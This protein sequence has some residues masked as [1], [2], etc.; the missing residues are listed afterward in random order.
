VAPLLAAVLRARGPVAGN[1][2]LPAGP[3]QAFLLGWLSGALWY[4]GSCYWVAYT[5]HIYGGLDM[6]ASL[7][8]LVLFCLWLGAQTG[9]FALL[10]SL[11][12]NRAR[13]PG[14]GIRRAL[15]CAPFLWVAIELV[16]TR[17]IGF[18][19]DLLGTAQVDNVPLTRLAAVTGVYGLSFEIMVVN[20][21]FAAAFLAQRRGRRLLLAAAV[22]A[23][24]ALQLSVFVQPPPAPAGA[25][26]RL[27]QENVPIGE[28]W[29]PETYRRTL[30]ELTR[31][32]MPP[33]PFES[34]GEPNA[35]LIV[36]PESPAP[37]FDNEPMF[38]AQIS[39]L[40]SQAHAY[41]I[42]GVLGTEAAPRGSLQPEQ[43][44]NSAALITPDGRW[45]AR[46]DKV[47]LVPFGEYVPFKKLFGFAHQLTRE[48]GDFVPGGQRRV[49]DLGGYRAGTFICYESTFPGEV[50]QFAANG[51][52]VLVTISND[53]WYGH[54]AAPY[55]HLN[56]ARMRAIENQRWLL[57]ATNTGITAAIDPYGR[58][59][60]EAPREVRT[61][62]SAPY[63]I[64][65]RTTFYTRHGDWFPWL[66]VIISLAC[67]LWPP[68]VGRK[69]RNWQLAEGD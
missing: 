25:T 16:R 43:L 60:A 68:A 3:G 17:I 45:A 44:F 2:L 59:V 61:A 36:W 49:F 29:T 12:A 37:F 69:D 57:R 52:Q 19:W 13:T 14:A 62:L 33:P 40:A 5:M 32:S 65:R 8:V 38:R 6:G 50:R 34:N 56:Q 31:E 28:N 1:D 24:L 27:V 46:Y 4:A 51:A 67:G 55:Q 9:L 66:C 42:A 21:A 48:V 23:A 11:I 30:D 63:G 64:V 41:V 18:P 20:A 7:G 47:H 35:D 22:L 10:L 15:A 58:V 54:T 53:E 39:R 26:A